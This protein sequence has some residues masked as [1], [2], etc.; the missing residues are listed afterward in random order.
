MT[1]KEEYQRLKIISENNI[2]VVQICTQIL[3]NFP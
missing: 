2:K 1:G 3:E